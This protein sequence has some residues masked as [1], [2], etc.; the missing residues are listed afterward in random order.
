MET[1]ASTIQH[2]RVL[3]VDH[4]GLTSRSEEWIEQRVGLDQLA[5]AEL[6]SVDAARRGGRLSLK[7]TFVG[8]TLFGRLG[9]LT[10]EGLF[11]LLA[12]HASGFNHLGN[13]FPTR[14]SC[15]SWERRR[16]DGREKIGVLCPKRIPKDKRH[17]V[18]GVRQQSTE[19]RSDCGA[20]RPAGSHHAQDCMC[21]QWH[22]A[23]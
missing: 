3:H 18:S 7:R 16:S 1:N 5:E 23:E 10:A 17:S 19:E 20:N 2:Q 21:H 9:G 4:N 12:Y 8:S 11:Y 6:R 22:T 15:R 13:P 14:H